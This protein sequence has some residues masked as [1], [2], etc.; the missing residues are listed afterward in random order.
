ML[1][2]VFNIPGRDPQRSYPRGEYSSFRDLFV[3]TAE[4][5]RM[6]VGE[7]RLGWVSGGQS[8]G[9]FLFFCLSI[10]TLF[11]FSFLKVQ[12]ESC[13]MGWDVW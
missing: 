9:S 1:R 3:P 12:E 7:R 10:E 5:F 13:V 2:D 8:E 4:F 6:C 11:L